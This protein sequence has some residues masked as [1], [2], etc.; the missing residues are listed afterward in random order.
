ML[1]SEGPGCHRYQNISRRLKG[2][3]VRLMKL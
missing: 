3:K 1:Y 2:E